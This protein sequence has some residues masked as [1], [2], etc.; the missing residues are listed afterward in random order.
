MALTDIPY[1][2]EVLYRVAKRGMFAV[3]QKFT[4][5]VFLHPRGVPQ[6]ILHWNLSLKSLISP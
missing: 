4:W 6:F 3:S 5:T 2:W 1:S